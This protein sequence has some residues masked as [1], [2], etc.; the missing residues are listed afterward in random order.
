MAAKEEMKRLKFSSF[1]VNFQPG[2]TS[3]STVLTCNQNG[4]W[5]KSR[6]EHELI[7]DLNKVNCK[8]NCI[9]ILSILQECIAFTFCTETYKR[10]L[11]DRRR[12]VLSGR[13]P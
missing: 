2:R 1:S 9:T 12:R 11:I 7:Y 13:D 3:A 10:S 8:Q 4:K 5:L 6:V